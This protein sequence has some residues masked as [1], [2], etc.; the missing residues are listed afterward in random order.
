MTATIK[1][2]SFANGNYVNA[3]AFAT[4]KE[5]PEFIA[6]SRL[7]E[8]VKAGTKMTEAVLITAIHRPAPKTKAKNLPARELLIS[9]PANF[10]TGDY[11]LKSRDD[12]S[13]SFKDEDNTIY[14][15]ISGNIVVEPATGERVKGTFKVNL[16][17]PGTDEKTFLLKG[18]FQ[19]L[20]AG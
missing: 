10:E 12:V 14:E 17:I 18:N 20:K 2:N 1:P 4:G 19:V 16:E 11:A 6:T 5:F 7:I 9:I 3:S 15:G 8:R 13:F